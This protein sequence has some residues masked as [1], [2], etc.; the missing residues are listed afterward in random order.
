MKQGR[1]LTLTC[2]PCAYTYVKNDVLNIQQS[3]VRRELA[4]MRS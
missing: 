4:S 2:I 3:I 1:A